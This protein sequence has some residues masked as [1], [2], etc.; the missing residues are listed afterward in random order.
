MRR[1][2][3]D[4]LRKC[5]PL[6]NIQKNKFDFDSGLIYGDCGEYYPMP[7]S[8]RDLVLE[9]HYSKAIDENTPEKL[10]KFNYQSYIK[11]LEVGYSE[12]LPKGN[13]AVFELATKE[14]YL[15]YF[16]QFMVCDVSQSND[17][18]VAVGRLY[19]VWVYIADNVEEFTKLLNILIIDFENAN[20]TFADC[21][22]FDDKEKLLNKLHLLIDGKQGKRIAHVLM[23]LFENGIID[24]K[25]IYSR[26]MEKLYNLMRQEFIFKTSDAS[27]NKFFTK[28]SNF[29]TKNEKEYSYVDT[30]LNS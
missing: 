24:K 15:S 14:V 3:F 27:I 8:V 28:Y 23:F 21:L 25:H 20:R 30:A 11:G 2:N 19:H 13:A 12:P 16:P 22:T 26:G 5:E 10:S 4:N 7:I 9:G 17:F 29:N 1:I 18:G 6:F